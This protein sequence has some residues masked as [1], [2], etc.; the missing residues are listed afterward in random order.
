MA[1]KYSDVFASIRFAKGE[2]RGKKHS[3]T[4]D[5][6]HGA[7]GEI[8]W[9]QQ[10]DHQKKR[11]MQEGL[12][13]TCW[14]GYTAVGMKMKNG[15]KVPNC[16]PVSEDEEG[17]AE[18]FGYR[19][20]PAHLQ[21]TLDNLKADAIQRGG[22]G[23]AL[24]G[25]KVGNAIQK[26]KKKQPQGAYFATQR[27]KARLANNGRMDEEILDESI[28]YVAVHAKK[29][30]HETH[31]NTSYEAA[32]NA[33]KHWK[34]KNT[35]GISVYRADNAQSTQ[36]VG[37]DLEQIDEMPGANMDTRAVHKH[38]RKSG[39][40]LTRTKGAH[41]VYTHP[42]SEKH[43]AVPRHKQLK[44]PLVR[45]IMK[46]AQVSEEIAQVKESLNTTVKT[47]HDGHMTS[48]KHH[49]NHVES[50]VKSGDY[51][52]HHDDSEP[53]HPATVLKHKSGK[54]VRVHTGD[55][56]EKNFKHTHQEITESRGHKILATKLAQIE[57]RKKRDQETAQRASEEMKKKEPV[58]EEKKGSWQKDTG[59]KKD[60]VDNVDKSGAKHSAMSRVKHLAKMA[61]KRNV[62][63]SENDVEKNNTPAKRTLGKSTEIVKNVIKS[64]KSKEE[65]NDTFQSEPELSSQIIRVN[66]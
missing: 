15:K 57:A 25:T 59:W 1:K 18:G 58:K 56:D 40:S 47:P 48:K 27:R 36:H 34:M 7:V 19:P 8:E 50:L 11:S 4:D 42:K 21:G 62:T 31:G 24:P 35:S 9:N 43:I 63:E 38:L 51:K 53:S 32:Q 2:P 26:S 61:A 30:K 55:R 44:A 66:Y 3:S 52:Y 46:D 17:V 16:V 5:E 65:K 33:A 23:S 39:W 37:E 49:D 10:L 54:L 45:G 20:P 22:S 12:K 41:D 29:G 60:K 28:P 64:K 14:K 6:E 13:D